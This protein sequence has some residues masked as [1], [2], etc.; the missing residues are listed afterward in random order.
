MAA[1]AHRGP[2]GTALESGP[3][4]T[5][6]HCLLDT[7]GGGPAMGCLFAEGDFLIVADC[8]IDNRD[9][10]VAALE[11]R[12]DASDTALL[13]GAFLRWGEAFPNHI[14]GDFALAI[15]DTR[16]RTLYCA[17]DHFGVKP[18]YYF[19]DPRYFVFASEPE[20]I[21]ASGLLERLV[22][23][24]RIADFLAGWPQ[25]AG[26]TSYHGLMRLLPAHYCTVFDDDLHAAAYWTLPR[27]EPVPRRDAPREFRRL[28]AEAIKIRFRGGPVGAMLSGG[29]DSSSIACLIT[30]DLRGE[31][32][33][34]L[35]TFSI[36]FDETPELNERPFIEAVLERG[37]FAP[38]F[39]Q[40]SRLA[41]LAELDGILHEQQDLFLGP[42][43]ACSRQIYRRAQDEGVRVLVDGHGGDEV[44]PIGAGRLHELAA[45]GRWIA[46]WR[47]LDAALVYD[48]L[49]KLPSFWAFVKHY[50]AFRR[51][52]RLPSLIRRRLG[53]AAQ[54][55]NSSTALI[56]PSFAARTDVIGRFRR[57]NARPEAAGSR[58]QAMHYETLTSPM[59]ACAFEILD[60]TAA[61]AGIDVRYPFW[62]R[63]LVEF[64][65]TLE[66]V[67]KLDRGWGRL[68]LRRAM[69]G[70]LPRAV[71]WRR[72][73]FDF[74]R[75]IAT[76]IVRDHTDLVLQTLDDPANGLG[77][78]VDLPA[79]R[80]MMQRLRSSVAQPNGF[81]VHAIFRVMVL[82]FWLKHQH[83]AVPADALV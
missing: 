23:D 5:L 42:N 81:E 27:P 7:A 25:P 12:H 70:I 28:L 19:S 65:L 50:S 61:A 29:L 9:E 55:P 15:W 49:R 18:F 36:V 52:L 13:L 14:L 79:A 53:A 46:L 75:H 1:L 37:G 8:R 51:F 45:Q 40:S 26:E 34:A 76:S 44:A 30:G 60:R 68:I 78:Y 35:P 72:Q 39:I 32:T 10:L 71:Q 17:R 82:A 2:D 80:L 24:E 69:E 6:G 57:Q 20:A 83:D 3:G 31:T 54:P 48:N 58:E 43:L 62:D 73:K 63:R 47:N 59:Q 41:H 21:F 11:Y 33:G 56:N 16:N 74:T 77:D 66:P 4:F 22:S 38:R 64:C 67:E